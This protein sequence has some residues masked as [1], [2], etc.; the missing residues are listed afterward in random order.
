MTEGEDRYARLAARLLI[1]RQAQSPPARGD[2]HRDEVVAAMALAIAAKARR[3]RRLVIATV[4]G[5]AAAASLIVV[6]RLAGGGGLSAA[7]PGA[8][9]ALV[10][11]NATARGNL[12]VRAS[13]ARPLPDQGALAVGDSVRC[14]E[15]SSATL[16][17][18]NGTRITLSS[19]ANLRVDDLGATRHFSLLQGHL[20]AHVAK[21][22]HGERFVVSTP[23]SDIEV[24][25]TVFTIA[26]ER[27]PAWCR[28]LASRSTV[29]VTE[30]TVWVRSG[31]RRVVLEP[32]QTWGTP[33]PEPRTIQ[34]TAG[35]SE[36]LSPSTAPL[37]AANSVRFGV[38]KHDAARAIGMRAPAWVRKEPGRAQ[39]DRAARDESPAPPV[40]VSRLAEQD[41]LFSAAMAAERQGQHD[42]ALRNLDELVTRFP[43]GP[44]EESARAERARILSTKA[45]QTVS[46]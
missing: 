12:L 17:F 24:R 23:D 20:N 21:L 46:P 22:D 8:G 33:C 1:E 38:H 43:G 29:N 4:A 44:L 45:P 32:G 25:G 42:L 30:G 3:R 40:S 37:P 34:A 19:S 39:G 35:E 15:D 11:E 27:S 6:F 2:V 5:L 41:D 26:V 9:S 31:D 36:E 28:D 7:K 10:V 16:G 14:A 13:V 18:A